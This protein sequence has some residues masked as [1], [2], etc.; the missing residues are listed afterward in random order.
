MDI[1]RVSFTDDKVTFH[2]TRL[3]KTINFK[4]WNPNDRRQKLSLKKFSNPKLC[5][6]QTIYEYIQHTKLFQNDVTA[7]FIVVDTHTMALLLGLPFHQILKK[8]GWVKAS[9]FV[10]HY[11]KP[12][13]SNENERVKNINRHRLLEY[14]GNQDDRVNAYDHHQFAKVEEFCVSHGTKSNTLTLHGCSR[15]APSIGRSRSTSMNAESTKCHFI[16]PVCTAAK[17]SSRVSP[18][19]KKLPHRLS[20]PPPQIPK[21]K[22]LLPAQKTSQAQ[23]S[24]PSPA[25]TQITPPKPTS[26]SILQ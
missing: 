21:L 14:W 19:A 17:S 7:L 23:E 10:N 15:T 26:P 18:P 20:P 6:V 24:A 22:V 1:N 13:L 3:T 16:P 25:C 4:N 5:L 11:M 8:V 12:I 9:T 2:L